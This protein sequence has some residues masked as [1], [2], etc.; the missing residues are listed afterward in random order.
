[1]AGLRYTGVA[2]HSFP[3]LA[4][5]GP[6]APCLGLTSFTD[7]STNT[8]TAPHIHRTQHPTYTGHSTPHTQGPWHAHPM[9]FSRKVCTDGMDALK[10]PGGKER[11][12]VYVSSYVRKG[13]MGRMRRRGA[14]SCL[15]GL[16]E[17]ASDTKVTAGSTEGWWRRWRH[18][19]CVLHS[20]ATTRVARARVPLR[21]ARVED[22]QQPQH[23]GAAAAASLHYTQTAPRP[24]RRPHPLPP[25]SSLPPLQPSPLPPS[26]LRPSVSCC[27][28]LRWL[29]WSALPH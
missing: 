3:D 1:V 19:Q 22:P 7:T 18:S 10:L 16:K 5:D 26:P 13:G 8:D 11:V 4:T 12:R 6:H 23:H 9:I 17:R 24:D 2:A 27:A 14:H 20:R 25:S 21:A 29:R 15:P 28:S